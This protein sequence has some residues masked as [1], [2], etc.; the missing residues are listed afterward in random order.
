M[1]AVKLVLSSLS[2]IVFGA[3]I[4]PRAPTCSDINIP[5]SLDTLNFNIDSD[6]NSQDSLKNAMQKFFNS[7]NTSPTVRVNGQYNIAA[8]YCE[9]E[10]RNATRANTIQILVHGITY[11]KD[12]WS[13]LGAPGN[14]FDGDTYSWIAY[15]SKQGYPTL[16]IDRLGN[17][18]S[19][20]PNGILDVQIGSHVEVTQSLINTL[21]SGSIGGR[22]FNKFIY[23]GHSYGSL[24]GNLHSV[25][26][27]NAVSAYVL[28]GF[29]QKIKASLIPV[30]FVG[31]FLPASVAFPANFGDAS[32]SY[33]AASNQTGANS[34]FFVNQNVDPALQAINFQTRGTVTA[35]EFI[36]AYA[37][38]Q[39]AALYRGRIFIQTGQNDA[40]FC[41]PDPFGQGTLN[42]RGDCGTGIF[43]IVASTRSNYPSVSTFDYDIPRNTGHCNILHKNAQAQFD[44]VHKWLGRFF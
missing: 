17:G 34:L 41:S 18:D 14:G 12:Y 29:T 31:G 6:L 23:V 43:S 1:L 20:R 44:T 8:R 9:P 36:S 40:I 2:T 26:Y 22:T 25:K 33:F 39:T 27:P 7:N 28:T 10:V 24:I 4:S 37:S 21:Q 35:G 15:A 42:G 16:S 19:D 32:L 13:G 38:T 11:T 3:T 5:V 30:L